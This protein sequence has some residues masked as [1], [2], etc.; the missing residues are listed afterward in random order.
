MTMM[1][2]YETRATKNLHNLHLDLHHSWNTIE[3]SNIQSIEEMM[4]IVE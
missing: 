3:E 1:M 4:R 2:V